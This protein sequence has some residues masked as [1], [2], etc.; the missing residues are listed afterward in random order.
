MAE[1]PK[2]WQSALAQGLVSLGPV[3][4]QRRTLRRQQDAARQGLLDQQRHQRDADAR[5]LQQVG[6]LQR[7]G[8][9]DER[10]AANEAF[11]L[12]LRRARQ[13]AGVP[14][15]P[16]ASDAFTMDVRHADQGVMGY[17][18]QLADLMA[19]ID[20][21][22]RQRRGEREGMART[23]VDIG[24][25][26]RDSAADDWLMRFRMANRQGNPWAPLIAA[27]G[28]AMVEGLGTR[29]PRVVPEIDVETLAPQ[30]PPATRPPSIWDQI[31]PRNPA[32]S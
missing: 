19:Q 31:L 2:P 22:L 28:G 23:A 8:P 27:I 24:G 3:L 18:R 25:I 21:P 16:G 13:N 15:V 11:M 1:Q 9:E 12:A 7:S 17:G 10:A 32:L 14:A 29:P 26:Q 30:L 5:V 20:A 6:D 4:D